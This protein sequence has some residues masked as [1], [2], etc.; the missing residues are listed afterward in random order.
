L[1]VTLVPGHEEGVV[2][3]GAGVAVLQAENA[4]DMTC[5]VTSNGI[6]FTFHWRDSVTFGTGSIASNTGAFD[7]IGAITKYINRHNQNP[8]PFIWTASARDILAGGCS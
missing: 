8:K 7:L 3:D 6:D 2:L 4:A 1:E 5:Q